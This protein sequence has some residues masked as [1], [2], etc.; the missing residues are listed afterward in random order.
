MVLVILSHHFALKNTS[1]RYKIEAQEEEIECPV[2]FQTVFVQSCL[3][4]GVNH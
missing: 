3:V 4:F 1:K 2:L